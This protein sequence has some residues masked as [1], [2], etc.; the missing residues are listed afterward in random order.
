MNRITKTAILASALLPTLAFAQVTS[1]LTTVGGV[2]GKIQ[3]VTKFLLGIFFLAAVVFIVL[4]AFKYLTAKG[5]PTKL[6]EAQK[7][8]VSA[9]VAIIIALLAYAIPSIAINFLG[10]DTPS[11]SSY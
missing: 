11:T 3:S 2:V 7:M 10:A 5:D 4:A 6:K 8:L 9:I 1:G